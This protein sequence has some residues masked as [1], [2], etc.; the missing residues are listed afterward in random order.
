MK[1]H[2]SAAAPGAPLRQMYASE[3]FALVL[4]SQ[5]SSWFMNSRRVLA[6]MVLFA[7]LPNSPDFPVSWLADLNGSH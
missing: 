1:P 7:S 3:R 6:K 4:I 5:G 2:A